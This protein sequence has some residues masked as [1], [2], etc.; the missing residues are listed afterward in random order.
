MNRR[1]VSRVNAIRAAVAIGVLATLPSCTAGEQVS[2]G[3][4]TGGGRLA[5]LSVA[6]LALTPSFSPDIHDYV[7]RCAATTNTLQ[8]S[9]TTT[10]GANVSLVTPTESD[11]SSAQ[12]TTVSYGTSARDATVRLAE[13]QAAVLRADVDGRSSEYWI[14]CLPHDFP[15]IT[16]TENTNAGRPADGFYLLSTAVVASTDGSFAMV[17]D[18]HGTPVW[19]RRAEKPVINLDLIAPNVLSYTVNAV[20]AG[21]GTDPSATYEL[22]DLAT[23]KTTYV[24]AVG[25]PTDVHEFRAL[26]SG[27]HLVQS[28]ALINGIDLTGLLQF[29]ADSTV[30]DCVLQEIDRSGALVWTWRAS[31]HIDIVRESTYPQK[32]FAQGQAVVDAIHCNSEDEA[33]NGDLLV[34]ARNLDAVFLIS[35]ATGKVIWKLGGAAYSRDGAQVLRLTGD[36]GFFRQHDAR[37]VSSGAITLF[38]DETGQMAPARAV[39]FAIDLAAGTATPAWQRTGSATSVVAMGSAR[40]QADGHVVVGWGGPTSG[41]AALTEFDDA[42]HDLLDIAFPSGSMSYRAIK[43]PLGSLDLGFLRRSVGTP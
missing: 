34:S 7:V 1:T 36:P 5:S 32:S 24:Q 39:A 30:A 8:L 28:Y 33:S 37:F 40:L 29:G 38:D 3:A 26:A 16:V 6:P 11:G 17:L 15:A 27:D 13:D 19:Y 25:S 21:F 2:G 18:I 4:A 12:S 23:A 31:D 43:V 22:H 41:S 10:G 35:K 14:R 9:W 20:P 42:G